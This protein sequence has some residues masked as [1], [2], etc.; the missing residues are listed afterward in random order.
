MWLQ[1]HTDDYVWDYVP[2]DAAYHL[3]NA[4]DKNDIYAYSSAVAVASLAC[5]VRESEEY[6]AYTWDNQ[7]I[8]WRHLANFPLDTPLDSI[9]AVVLVAI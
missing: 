7:E 5:I 8:N 2:D 6:R 9:K 4:R 1:R 3:M